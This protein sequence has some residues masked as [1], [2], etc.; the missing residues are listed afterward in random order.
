MVIRAHVLSDE[1]V[2]VCTAIPLL[3]P[4]G[5]VRLWLVGIA[6]I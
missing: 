3:A 5:E 6:R 2:L 1:Y 4:S